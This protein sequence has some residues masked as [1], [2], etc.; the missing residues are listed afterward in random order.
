[1]SDLVI[2]PEAAR[3]PML[4]DDALASMADDIAA[5][6]LRH[7]VV[8]D[9]A[10]RVI[11]GRNRLAA[12]ELAGVEPAF[13]TEELSDDEAIADYVLSVN[14]ENRSLTNGQKAMYRADNLARQ[15]KRKNGRW[16]RG[17]VDNGRF[18]D[19]EGGWLTA[20]KKAGFVIDVAARAAAL[21]DAFTSFVDQPAM[22]MS[23][24][25]T[26]DAAHRI[27]QDF[28]AKAAMA[29]MAVWAPFTKVAAELEQLSL[30]VAQAAELPIVDA[31]LSK[32]HRTQLEDT[33]KRFA[34]VANAIRTYAKEAK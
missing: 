34:A 29:E 16:E 28:D 1:M 30:D 14:V 15:G 13:V 4:S 9:T 32:K 7:P 31:P 24:E 25:L 10:G 6:G 33:A 23:G 20:M 11:D 27:A 3:F 19:I 22:V 17:T 12:C 26:L 8:L 18:A 5:N 21:G 2:H